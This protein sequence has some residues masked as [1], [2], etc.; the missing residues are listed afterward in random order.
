M[1]LAPNY[2][3]LELP[4][5]DAD[6]PVV[7]YGELRE[8]HTNEERVVRPIYLSILKRQVKDGLPA[9]LREADEQ[10]EVVADL[11]DARVVGHTWA[12]YHDAEDQFDG[13]ANGARGLLP[14]DHVLVAE[15]DVIHDARQLA[16]TSEVTLVADAINRYRCNGGSLLDMTPEQFVIGSCAKALGD[17]PATWLVDI[18]PFFHW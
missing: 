17:E 15:V 2:S 9:I 6:T 10:L 5:Y 1:L 11:C 3:G 7:S 8:L 4:V 13:I 14:E 12:L 18:E 16:N